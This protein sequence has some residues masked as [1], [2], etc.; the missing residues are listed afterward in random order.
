[1]TEA[2]TDVRKR[3]WETRRK[4]YGQRGHSGAY[5]S[6]HNSIRLDSSTDLLVRLWREGILSEGQVS[7]ATGLDRVS[8]RD[9]AIQQAHRDRV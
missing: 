1:M 2:L 8:C 4:K 6:P 9:L 3:A 7:R 5:S